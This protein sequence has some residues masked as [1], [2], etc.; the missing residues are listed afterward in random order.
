MVGDSTLAEGPFDPAS[1][2]DFFK[3]PVPKLWCPLSLCPQISHTLFGAQFNILDI[4]GLESN[5]H[6]VLCL[7]YSP[8]LDNFLFGE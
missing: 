1:R 4:R 3:G 8:G 7:S 6:I 5:Y 2:E